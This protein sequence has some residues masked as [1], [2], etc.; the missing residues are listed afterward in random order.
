MLKIGEQLGGT[1]CTYVVKFCKIII[2]TAIYKYACIASSHVQ[3]QHSP[4]ILHVS[5]QYILQSRSIL[6]DAIMHQS[7]LH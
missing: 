6:F 4:N 1:A 3:W 2:E 7:S 5:M